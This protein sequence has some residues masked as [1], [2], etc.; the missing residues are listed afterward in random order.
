[1]KKILLLTAALLLAASL[2]PPAH[3]QVQENLD[4]GA[5]IGGTGALVTTATVNSAAQTN[6]TN[7]GALCQLHQLSSS[8]TA[9]ITFAIQSLD[10]ASG[11]WTSLITSS[12]ITS[13]TD[14]QISVYPGGAVAANV[15]ANVH[16]PRVWRV[17]QVIG[18]TGG[19]AWNVSIGCNLLN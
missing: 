3:A 4:L 10:A 17:Q 12:S 19:P 6:S 5:I 11:V 13:V 1:M 16:L 18:G 7:K 2:T 8:G 14:T 15:S 9:T